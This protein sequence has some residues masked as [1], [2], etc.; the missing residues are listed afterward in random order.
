MTYVQHAH[1]NTYSEF[2]ETLEARVQD[3]E[4]MDQCRKCNL[5]NEKNIEV[6]LSKQS[7]LLKCN[8]L[9]LQDFIYFLTECK[10]SYSACK[11]QKATLLE[12]YC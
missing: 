12:H 1:R 10:I 3:P 5:Q 6:V 11:N 4:M 8:K 7:K 9:P 2:T